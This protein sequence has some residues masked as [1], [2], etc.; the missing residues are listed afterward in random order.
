MNLKQKI[1][2]ENARIAKRV[3]ELRNDLANEEKALSN[4]KTEYMSA[5]AEDEEKE[6]D[7]LHEQ[8]KA[9]TSKVNRTRDLIEALQEKNNPAVQNLIV[10]DVSRWINQLDQTEQEAQ[11]KVVELET[12]RKEYLQGLHE[13]HEMYSFS[14]RLRRACNSYREKLNEE[15]RVKAELPNYPLDNLSPISRNIRSLLIHAGEVFK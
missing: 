5:L 9:M 13:L 12:L 15:N 2:A 3:E 1:E 7:S 4:L 6:V 10:E 11:K 8:I 14:N